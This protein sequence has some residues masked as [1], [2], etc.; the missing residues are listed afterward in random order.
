MDANWIEYERRVRRLWKHDVSARLLR[1]TTLAGRLHR[2]QVVVWCP[3]VP[4][5]YE[6][7]Q[8][9]TMRWAWGLPIIGHRVRRWSRYRAL[10][11]MD[12]LDDELHRQ[13]HHAEFT[14]PCQCGCGCGQQVDPGCVMQQWCA[15]CL[16]KEVRAEK[17]GAHHL[18]QYETRS[19]VQVTST[20]TETQSE[21]PQ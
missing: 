21:E 10:A 15:V 3:R 6:G 18:P 16:V 12:R 17:R 20:T 19:D 14:I 11:L 9:M 5:L 2:A 8:A 4:A 7:R 13:C 1:R